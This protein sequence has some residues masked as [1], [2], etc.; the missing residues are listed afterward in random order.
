ME[1]DVSFVLESDDAVASRRQPRRRDTKQVYY[2]IVF[3]EYAFPDK[4]TIRPLQACLVLQD[5]WKQ[6]GHFGS[7]LGATLCNR[8]IADVVQAIDY[9]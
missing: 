1:E 2:M 5:E 4:L 7:V 6:K 9:D 3:S 8:N